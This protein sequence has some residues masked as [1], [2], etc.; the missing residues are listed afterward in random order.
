MNGAT[1]DDSWSTTVVFAAVVGLWVAVTTGCPIKGGG[2]DG[3][4]ASDGDIAQTDDGATHG[5]CA[6]DTECPPSSSGGCVHPREDGSCADCLPG[7]CGALGV[8]HPELRVCVQCASDS[9]CPQGV[10]H[11]S[12]L[13]CVG[14]WNDSH[15]PSVCGVGNVCAECVEDDHCTLGVCNPRT[16]GCIGGCKSHNDCSDDNP[17]TE[18]I[19][20]AD[21]ECVYVPLP[22]GAVCDSPDECLSDAFCIGGQCAASRTSCCPEPPVCG[23]FAVS[24]DL[25]GDGCLDGCVCDDGTASSDPDDPS[26]DCVPICSNDAVTCPAGSQP[27]DLDG[28]GCED[29]CECVEPTCVPCDGDSA[30]DDGDPCSEDICVN[31]VCVSLLVPNC[32]GCQTSCDCLAI[33]DPDGFAPPCPLSCETC[34]NFWGCDGGKCVVTCGAQPA[35]LGSCACDPVSCAPG[36]TP[37]DTDGD[38]CAD[39]CLCPDGSISSEDGCVKPAATCATGC[40]CVGLPLVTNDLCTDACAGCKSQWACVKGTC[41]EVCGLLPPDSSACA[42]DNLCKATGGTYDPAACGDYVCGTPPDCLAA[43]GGCDC[44]PEDV[45]DPTLGC[46]KAEDCNAVVANS[47]PPLG[48]QEK[49]GSVDIDGDGCDDLC[50]CSETAGCGASQLCVKAPGKCTELGTCATKPDGCVETTN[51]AV[52]ACDGTTYSSACTAMSAGQSVSYKGACLAVTEG[53][54]P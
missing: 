25:D 27:T 9:D 49:L 44:G 8:C 23:T 53:A 51:E 4:I 10:C 46:V 47:C 2:D 20:D 30:C 35:G 50:V 16:G 54:M 34:G 40:D 37:S 15:C 33:G 39:A 42:G 26:A 29:E 24:V 22:D 31:N 43:I 45:F 13:F 41:Q 7:D 18:D 28:D 48:C 6:D 19:C 3:S 12:A 17:C 14:C 52:C 1:M 5:D 21:H 11:P 36:T 38:A 32:G